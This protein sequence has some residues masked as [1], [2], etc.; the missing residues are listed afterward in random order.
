MKKI[1][2]PTDF[3]GSSKKAIEMAITLAKNF[4]TEVILL[5]VLP[6]FTK[7]TSVL[8]LMSK[9][10]HFQLSKIQEYL[11]KGGVKTG[12]PVIQIGNTY[13]NI[14]EFANKLDVNLILMGSGKKS[15]EEPFKL[16]ITSENVIRNSDIPVWIVKDDT[17]TNISSIVCPVDFSKPSKRAL[18]NAIHLARVFKAELS[19]FT[20]IRP[21]S[22]SFMGLG[23]VIDQEQQLIAEKQ[24][25]LFNAFLTKFDFDGIEYSKKVLTGKPYK[26]IL[27]NINSSANTLLIMGTTGKSGITKLLIGSVTEKVVREVPCSF[28]TLKSKDIIRLKTKSEIKILSYHFKEGQKM[29]EQGFLDDALIQFKI[30]LTINSLYI[31]AWEGRAKT[32]KRLGNTKQAKQSKEQA[33][34]IRA[35]IYNQQV[36]ADI[37]S[38]H[39]LFGKM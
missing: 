2:L 6:D 14:I 23:T 22:E 21:P 38:K 39:H 8:D 35:R 5:H 7:S 20:V 37:R 24:R 33:K 3:S 18:T 19:V 17:S 15:A 16:G 11:H 30:C 9:N 12:E 32:E 26:E 28:I 34:Q 1:L 36:E 27:N 31:P 29:L 25:E 10:V 13:H 4:E